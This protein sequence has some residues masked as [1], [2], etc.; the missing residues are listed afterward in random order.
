VLREKI[1][2]IDELTPPQGITL[3]GSC[4]AIKVYE[5]M[6]DILTSVFEVT[7][8]EVVEKKSKIT[9]EGV[10]AGWEVIK[11]LDKYSY[12]HFI[13]SLSGTKNY[14]EVNIRGYLKTEFLRE[15]LWQKSI[16]YD[17]FVVMWY[18]YFYSKK[19]RKEFLEKGKDIV[20][21]FCENVKLL[22]K[23]A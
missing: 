7:R 11:Y 9:E 1:M 12:Y 21:Y 13:I 6:F 22:I 18:E 2:F 4:E 14:A 23:G 20:R 16:L 3:S 15:H 5:K 17:F 19:Q 8:F 10:S